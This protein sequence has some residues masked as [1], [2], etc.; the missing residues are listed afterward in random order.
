MLSYINK[1]YQFIIEE[2]EIIVLWLVISY[3]DSR[4]GKTLR[5]KYWSKKLKHHGKNLDIHMR[6]TIGHPE[7]VEI[8]NNFML[9]VNA[10]MTA[11]GSKGIFIGDNVGI[12]RGSCLHAANHI[13][14]DVNIPTRLQGIN[15]EDI[16]YNKKYYSII[17]EEDVLIGSNVVILT[18]SKISK[19]SIV[20][21]GSVVSGIYPPYSVLVGNPA[22]ISQNRKQ[23]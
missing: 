3:P 5:R 9:S 20:S 11:F 6:S 21:P 1:I 22:R 17:I 14:E 2:F 13:S 15:S 8:G 4:F 12:G 18:G 7:L 16:L 23:K 19:G 10:H